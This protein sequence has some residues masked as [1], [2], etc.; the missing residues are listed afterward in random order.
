MFDEY[1]KF[2][3]KAAEDDELFK[4]FKQN[5]VYK[6]ILE[7]VTREQ[8]QKYFPFIHTKL[9]NIIDDNIGSPVKEKYSFGTYSPTTLRYLSIATD[10]YDIFGFSALADKSVVEIGAG[11]GGQ[12][13]ILDKIFNF[14][15][16]SFVDL[17]GAS[18]L[19]KKYISN[20]KYNTLNI[21]FGIPSSIDFVI[22][23]Y[24]F[25]ELS[26]DIQEIYLKSIILPSKMGY[27]ILN[28]EQGY[29]YQELLDIIPNSTIEKNKPFFGRNYQLVWKS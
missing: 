2:C 5:P 6:Q 17:P 16:Y 28:T 7:H 27:M 19:I 3:S 23:N 9:L 12:F 25:S 15:F 13:L 22:S 11:Y 4:T 21:S 18:K 20:F 8:G 24:A 26:R 14:D 1:D 10:I 29:S